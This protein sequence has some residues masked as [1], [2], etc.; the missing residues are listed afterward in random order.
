LLPDQLLPSGKLQHLAVETG[1]SAKIY[2]IDRDNFGKVNPGNP[3]I[4]AGTDPNVLQTATLG[5]AGVWG[6]P[7]FLPNPDGTPGGTLYYQG[8]GDVIKAFKL[9]VNQAGT[10]MELVTP[11]ISQGTQSIAFPGT[12]PNISSNNG[13]N[14]IAWTVQVNNFGAQGPATLHAY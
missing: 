13:T 12:Q 7:S 9:Q 3:L 6:S 8:S 5:P 11:P 10:S 14:A 1:K 2:L 4:S